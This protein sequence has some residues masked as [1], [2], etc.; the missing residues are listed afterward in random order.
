MRVLQDLQPKRV[1]DF[2]E[3]ICAIPHGSGNTAQIAEYCLKFAEDRDL[4]AWQDKI[5]N[6]IMKKAASHGYENAEPVILQGHL[7]M[8]TEKTADCDIDF[9]KD[10]L[11][12]RVDGDWISAEGTTLGGD[13]GIA[14]AMAL[15]ILDDDTIEHPALEVMLTV[16]EETGMY[17]AADLE[18]ENIRG[19]TLLNIDSEIEGVFTVSCAGGVGV[20]CRLQTEAE[21]CKGGVVR[22]TVEGLAGGHSGVEI[23]HGRANACILLGRLL[24]ELDCRIVSMDGGG[25]DN[26]IARQATAVV[27]VREDWEKTV[28]AMEEKFREEYRTTDPNL[29]I[30]VDSASA[31]AAMTKMDTARCV[32]FL[33]GCPNGIVAMS[34]DIEGLVQ[35]SLNLGILKADAGHFRASFSVRSSV[36]AEK[37]QLVQQLKDLT[38]D[39]GGMVETEGDYPAWEYRKDSPLRDLMV[40]AYTEQYGKPPVVEAIHAGLECGLLSDKLPGLD[41]VSIGPDMKDIHTPQERLSVSSVARVWKFVLEVLKRMK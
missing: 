35:T 7:D 41:A 36:G 40:A 23:H 17:G 21:P 19:R 28:R 16:D 9:T 30:T 27:E 1:F 20:I 32:A 25:K 4:E 39:L 18:P 12:L 13:D 14:V 11:H 3:D 26:A 29:K 15:A 33:T 6:V 22:L 2:F 10:G 38:A 34:E 31:D 37:T 5:G 8:V 24:K